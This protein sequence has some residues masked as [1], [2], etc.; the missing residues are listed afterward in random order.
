MKKKKLGPYEVYI[1]NEEEFYGLKRE[2][3]GRHDYWTE[4]TNPQPVIIDAGAH[5][6]LS[7]LY[8]AYTF[9]NSQI[10]ALEP[11]Q[12]SFSLLEQNVLMNRLETRVSVQQVALSFHKNKEADFFVDGSND[13]WYST[14]SILPHG[15]N[16]TQKSKK[17]RVA[18][19]PLGKLL[20]TEVDLLKMDIEGVEQKVLVHAGEQLRLVRQLLIEFHPRADQS[21]EELIE[22]LEKLG[23]TTTVS[24]E[25]KE[26]SVSKATGLVLIAGVR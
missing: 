3:W 24:K 18:T 15:W 12:E 20:N 16:G 7:T 6:G 21:L 22:F 17:I 5:I 9:P 8:Y 2:I 23:F 1:E 4:I 19:M 14:S 13:G 10:V 26:V 25:G 11:N